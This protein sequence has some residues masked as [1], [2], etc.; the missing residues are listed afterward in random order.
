MAWK[1]R[2]KPAVPT[3]NTFVV[4]WIWNACTM[5]AGMNA[6]SPVVSVV[7]LWYSAW[8]SIQMLISPST[9]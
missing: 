7:L 8:S 3:P 2:S 4:L 6:K 9:T 1:K 5:F